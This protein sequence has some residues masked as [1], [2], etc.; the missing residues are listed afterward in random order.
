MTGLTVPATGKAVGLR[1]Q[2]PS[3]ACL[4]WSGRRAPARLCHSARS[5][6]GRI[7]HRP[8]GH[9]R[10]ADLAAAQHPSV[11]ALG[12][13]IV[14]VQF[15]SMARAL[16]RYKERLVGHDAAL[17]RHGRCPSARI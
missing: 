4:V 9:L 15:F 8:V 10:L 11:V 7:R 2:H 6:R 17:P 1:G 14:G 12:V 13:A 16:F 5:R 3:V